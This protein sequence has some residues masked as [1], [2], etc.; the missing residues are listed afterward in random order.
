VEDA[1]DIRRRILLAFEK[2]ERETDEATRRVLLT[3]VIVGGGATGVEVAG[4]IAEIACEVVVRD[5]RR[6]P[7]RETRTIL[8]EAGPRILPAFPEDLAAKAE[9]SLRNL[10]VEVRT[11]CPVTAIRPGGVVAGD[12]EISAATVLWAAGVAASPLARSLGV[13][14][15]R[16]GRVLVT[17]EL[18]V[19]DHAE[20]FVIGDL[21]ACPD[22]AGQPL[23]GLAPVAMQQGRHAARNIIRRCRG[24]PSEAFRY[25]NRG[26]LATIGRHAAVADFRIVKLSGFV[27]WVAWTFVHIFFLIGFRSKIAVL[28]EWAWAYVTLRRSARLITGG[29]SPE[30]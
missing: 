16:A 4:A 22:E 2:A 11:L 19:P 27:A 24:L 7:P 29:Q 25:R 15:D 23:P 28:F 3:F 1:L 21:A 13:E 6:I 5:Y 14:L 8:L 9:T 26:M 18:S 12:H 17:P 20:V 10:G 30:S